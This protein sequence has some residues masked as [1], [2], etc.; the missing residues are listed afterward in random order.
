MT[1]R[2]V[3]RL[4]I[5]GEL[6]A[7]GDGDPRWNNLGYWRD[8]NEYT[9][10]CQALARRHGEVA[11]LGNGDRVL[12]LGC[13]HGV[14]LSLWC[15]AFAV[16]EAVGL[17]CRA[18]GYNTEHRRVV[19]RFDEPLPD[20]LS[21]YRFDVI[22]C[23]D[24][25]YHASSLSALLASVIPVL[26][27]EGRLALSLL[28][29]PDDYHARPLFQRLLHQWLLK[30]A[31]LPDASFCDHSAVQHQLLACGFLDVVCEDLSE[32]VFPG[33]Y[34]WVQRRHRELVFSRRWS[35]GWLKI[36]ITAIWCYWMHRKKLGRYLLVSATRR[37][38][39]Q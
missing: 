19:G 10:A 6:L 20:S 24:A 13:G 28:V 34:H 32:D 23:V 1:A 33:F 8:A 21:R 30:T 11:R 39:A 14:A 4:A 37:G 2:Q 15:D 7:G 22:L 17:D 38:I 16:T 9:A 29:R 25:A 26:E 31:G 5:A 12:E 18:S 3:E 36:R 35:R 27:R